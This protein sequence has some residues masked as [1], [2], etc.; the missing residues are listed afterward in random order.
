MGK[1][2]NKN[3]KKAIRLLIVYKDQ[4]TQNLTFLRPLNR[5]NC[6]VAVVALFTAIGPERPRLI[7]AY[8]ENDGCVGSWTFKPKED[9]DA[10]DAKALRE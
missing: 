8:D 1:K 5:S 3:K 2:Q 4:E 6:E 7:E 10:V 9:E